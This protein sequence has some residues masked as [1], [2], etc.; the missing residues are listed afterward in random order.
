VDVDVDVD[1]GDAG[2]SAG[3]SRMLKVVPKPELVEAV[4]HSVG[5]RVVLHTEGVQHFSALWLTYIVDTCPVRALSVM[6][7]FPGTTRL[8]GFSPAHSVRV[9]AW[10]CCCSRGREG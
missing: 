10:L 6:V 1:V 5:G 4:E 9:S 2:V 3:L 8:G 7:A